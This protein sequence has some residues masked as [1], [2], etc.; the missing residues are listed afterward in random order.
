MGQSSGHKDTYTRRGFS[1]KEV[2]NFMIA[3]NNLANPMFRGFN[4]KDM[5]PSQKTYTRTEGV[6][7]KRNL[8]DRR[9]V[10][11]RESG[12]MG[13]FSNVSQSEIDQLTNMF[14]SRQRQLEQKRLAPGRSALF[15]GGR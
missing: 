12:F 3:G 13:E 10:F 9:E 5:K 8:F 2:R 14:M 11:N 6:T 15:L 4:I 7:G 1:E